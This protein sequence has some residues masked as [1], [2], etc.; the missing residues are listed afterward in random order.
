MQFNQNINLKVSN[1]EAESKYKDTIPKQQNSDGR[2][3]SQS[4]LRHQSISP[5]YFKTKLTD[6]N[7]DRGRISSLES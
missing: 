5:G 4:S 3:K 1:R 2:H 7:R 6:G